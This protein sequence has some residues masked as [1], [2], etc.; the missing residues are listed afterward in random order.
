MNHKTKWVEVQH[1]LWV[2]HEC[3]KQCQSCGCKPPDNQDCD[4]SDSR[5]RVLCNHFDQ[6]GGA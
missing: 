3:S 6:L 5:V 1:L 4:G 2:C